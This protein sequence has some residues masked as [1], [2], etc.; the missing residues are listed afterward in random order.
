M[1]LLCAF[2]V[3]IKGPVIFLILWVKWPDFNLGVTLCNFKEIANLQILQCMQ[4]DFNK[5]ITLCH[6]GIRDFKSGM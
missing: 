6:P 2:I 4:P 3:R 5:E 1:Y